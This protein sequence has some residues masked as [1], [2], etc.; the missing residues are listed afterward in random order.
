MIDYAPYAPVDTPAFD[1]ALAK[2]RTT[3][4]E[5]LV[6]AD[7]LQDLTFQTLRRTGAGR[8]E[9]VFDDWVY[10]LGGGYEAA[11]VGA[12]MAG[13]RKTASGRW[14]SAKSGKITQLRVLRTLISDHL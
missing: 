5:L 10:A 3:V 13:Y 6:A 14:M 1:T 7:A 2:H 11:V 8:R 12:E 9:L 4:T